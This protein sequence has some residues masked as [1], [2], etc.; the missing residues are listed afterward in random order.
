M[1]KPELSPRILNMIKIKVKPRKSPTAIRT[2]LSRIRAKYPFLTLNAAAEVYAKNHNFSISKYLDEKDRESLSRV[3]LEKIVIRPQQQPTKLKIIEMAK[4]DTND[5]LLK[6][7]LTEINKAY[8]CGCY[9]ATFVICRKVL[10]NL[11]IHHILRKKFPEIKKEHREK[12]FDF[13]KSRFLNFGIVIKNLRK[14]SNEFVAEKKLVERICNLA[15]AFKD[16]AND[17]TH[18]LYHIA[19]KKEIDNSQFQ[20]ILDLIN[21]LEKSI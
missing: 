14:S 6:A 17:M 13:K 16:P 18:S 19:T 4:Y 15:V 3:T 11:L 1:R 7:H 5:K 21:D 12:Y 2:A 20:T 10:E 9:T 8:T